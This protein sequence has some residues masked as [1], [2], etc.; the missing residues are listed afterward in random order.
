MYAPRYSLVMLRLFA[1]MAAACCL[2]GPLVA[3]VRAQSEWNDA[4]TMALVLR[5]T[6]LRERQLAD[7]ALHD[8]H[9]IARGYLTFLAQLGEGFTEPPKVIK[10][11]ELAV[12]VY[13]RAPGLSKQRI[14]GRRDTLLLPT[15]IAYHRDHL[16]IIQN[17]FPERI[18]IGD[19]D[20]VRDVPHPLSPDGLGVYEFAIGDSIEMR[21]PDRTIAVAIVRVRPV[22]DT[23]PR[24]VG[25]L[26]IERES[27]QVVRMAFN[28]TRAAFV[29]R[30]LEDL[31]I[32]LDNALVAGRF[33]LPRRQEI[34]IRRSGTWMD[35]PV[36]GIIRGRWEICCQE[37]N[38]GL[39]LALFS[40]PEIVTAPRRV[41]D[42]HSWGGAI[43]DSLPPD[44][45][46]P[47]DPEVRIIQEEARRLVRAQALARSRGATVAARGIS[48]IARVRRAEGLALGAGISR[49]LGGGMRAALQAR[50]GVDDE[51]LKA[52]A[53][54]SWLRA[55]GIGLRVFGEREYRDAGDIT[56]RSGLVNSIA[57]QEFG[58][59]A[60]E[61]FD[62]RAVGI[63]AE[64]GRA[65]GMSW[66]LTM[67]YERH[68]PVRVVATPSRGR[69]EPVI[70][71]HGARAARVAL[72]FDRPTSLFVGGTELR[73][74]GEARTT[75]FRADRVTLPGGDSRAMRVFVDASV[76]RPFGADRLVSR[77]TFAA[78]HGAQR[79]APAQELVYL[80]GPVSGPG[81]QFHE[82]TAE[83]GG[84]QRLEW[85]LP[86]P[87]FAVPL[88]RFGAAPPR[89]TV[90]PFVHTVFLAVPRGDSRPAQRAAAQRAAG[91]YPSVGVSALLFFD[92]IRLDAA[93]GLRDGRWTFSVDV[94]PE[95]WR[96][97]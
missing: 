75:W 79:S 7:T 57:A 21:L 87:F 41:M 38:S 37:V 45:R 26:F 96:V 54:V 77:T 82:L 69:Y 22:D 51:Q 33:W 63:A 92:A 2:L 53:E 88:G 47:T 76:E 67:A 93:R 85:R 25:A 52:R 95:L 14:I 55:S 6:E 40:G 64:L 94:T 1:A 35:F 71:A 34:E 61:P 3:P 39:D 89:M 29:D 16:G 84:S 68:E 58:S 8:W 44:V 48:D 70:D 50:Y 28:F 59:D 62:V 23:Q 81:Y 24:V 83:I 97:L 74:R 86:A 56:E 60:T 49:A 27:A 42:V 5:A 80:G 15:D 43:L 13:W 65:A 18:R 20:E 90:A 91:W 11:D 66:R 19:G 10:A 36:R 17:N 32:V 12:E 9:A 30:Q 4:R 46:A 78:V 73:V 72:S 31:A